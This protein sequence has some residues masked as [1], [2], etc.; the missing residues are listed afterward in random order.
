[1]CSLK[2][3][4]LVFRTHAREKMGVLRAERFRDAL[5]DVGFIVPEKVMN[6]LVLRYMR[7]DGMLRFGDFVSA[8]MHLHRAFGKSMIFTTRSTRITR[9]L[10]MDS[11]VFFVQ[12]DLQ[13]YFLRFFPL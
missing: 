6:L 7:K 5:R 12:T 13:G 9:K 8:V 4:Q 2:H 11:F 3:W 1:M 10:L